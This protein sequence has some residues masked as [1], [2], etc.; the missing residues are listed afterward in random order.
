MPRPLMKY[1]RSGT[2]PR[3][4]VG[5]TP[6]HAPQCPTHTPGGVSGR[7][8]GGGVSSPGPSSPTRISRGVIW[9]IP[10][11]RGCPAH[12]RP[13]PTMMRRG[14]REASQTTPIIVGGVRRD[15]SSTTTNHG[16][17]GFSRL[18]LD[19]LRMDCGG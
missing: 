1:G 3:G 6:G 16:R 19:C 12:S 4:S 11:D 14:R 5:G 17:P 9:R 10:D 15:V 13:S 18:C 8:R 2:T 7:Q